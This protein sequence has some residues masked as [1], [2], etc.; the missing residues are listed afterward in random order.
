MPEF[1]P[2]EVSAWIKKL[3]PSFKEGLI[4]F[5]L[6]CTFP[7]HQIKVDEPHL[8]ATANFWNSTRHVFHFNAVDI[9]PTLEEFSALMGEPE[10]NTLILLTIGRDLLSFVQALLCVSLDT[11]QHWCMIDKLNIVQFLH[12]PLG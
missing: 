10:V 5:G 8:C 7:Y 4:P 11:A 12:T 2:L 3:G 6:S 9:C 1:S